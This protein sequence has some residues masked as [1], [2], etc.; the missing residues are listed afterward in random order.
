MLHA[1]AA[2][3]QVRC[4]G[5]RRARWIAPAQRS[6]PVPASRRRFD[7][8]GRAPEHS[9][10]GAAGVRHVRTISVARWRWTTPS[11]HPSIWRRALLMQSMQG[12]YRFLLVIR[13][14][15]LRGRRAVARTRRPRLSEVTDLAAAAELG[16]VAG[17]SSDAISAV[18]FAFIFFGVLAL[19]VSQLWHGQ[20]EHRVRWWHFAGGVHR[21]PGPSC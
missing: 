13:V 21:L 15:V 2:L 19:S 20:H 10:P 11:A 3:E 5:R 6:R 8:L 17:L 14:D 1:V 16:A 12:S 18:A 9:V 4:C 7:N